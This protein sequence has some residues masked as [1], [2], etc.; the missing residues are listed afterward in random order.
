MKYGYLMAF[1]LFLGNCLCS[2]WIE[3]KECSV[4]L[5]LDQPSKLALETEASLM[6]DTISRLDQSAPD[7]KFTIIHP[8]SDGQ[9]VRR[10]GSPISLSE[11]EKILIFQGDDP[12]E[13][14][15]L[16][17]DK[18]VEQL[19]KFYLEPN[20]GIVLSGGACALFGKLGY[21]PIKFQRIAFG[22]DR[23]QSGIV[24][25]NPNSDLFAN[26]TLDR[27]TVWISNAG[28][29]IYTAMKTES[30][31][32]VQYATA[33]APWS[34]PL[35]CGTVPL[36]ADKPESKKNALFVFPWLIHPVYDRAD[37]EFRANFE[38]LLLNLVRRSGTKI[39]PNDLIPPLWKKPDFQGLRLA[40][41]DIAESFGSEYS[42]SGKYLNRIADLEK[43]SESV[44]T[45]QEADILLKEFAALQKEALLANPMLDFNE[46]LMIRR[47]PNVKSFPEN[48]NGNSVLKPTGYKNELIR[49][50]FRKESESIVYKPE[51]DEFLGDI[52][53]HYDADKL[54]FSMPD[55][56]NNSRWRVWELPLKSQS[57]PVV[58]PLINVNDV[59]NYD[60]CYLPDDRIIFCSTA[61]FTGVPCINGSGHVCNLYLKEK[62]GSIRQ[63]TIDQDHDWCPTVMNN[64]RIMYLRWEYTDLPHAFSRILFHMNPDGTNQS[65]LYG[66]GSYWPNSLFYARPIP[67]HPTKFA[68][69]VTG[70]H[71]MNRIGDL[72][73]F[74]PAK[75]RKEAEGAI[76]RIPGRGKRVLPAMLD[77]PIAQSWPK[78]VHPF[79][80]SEKY[81]L[82]SCKLNASSPWAIC[83]VDVFDNIVPI[84]EEKEFAL[85]EP[86]P[87]RKADRPAVIPD[88]IKPKRSDADVFI[89]DIYQGEGLKGVP[90]GT[91]HALRIFSYQFGYQGMGAEPHS[92]G[93]DGPWDPKRIIGTV[94]VY[95]DGSAAFKIPA[96]TP[97]AFQ[98]LD[99][100]GKAIQIMRS[101]ITAMPGESVSCIGCHEKQNETSPPAPRTIA[102]RSE[103]VAIQPFYGL[104]RGFS[105]DREIQPILD[106]Y[107]IECHQPNSEKAKKILA[108]KKLDLQKIFIP[109]FRTGPR[110]P[111]QD[112]TLSINTKA[113]FS[114]SY[115]QLRRFVRTPTKESQMPIHKPY[116]FHADSTHLIQHLQKGHYGIQL[117]S[118]SWD[119]LF[120]WIDLNAPYHGNWGE[121]RNYEAAAQVAHQYKRRND[122]RAL[123][124]GK[125]PELEDDPNQIRQPIPIAGDPK[126]DP[127]NLLFID[128]KTEIIAPANG[129]G[130]KKAEVESLPLTEGIDLKLVSIPGTD[131]KIGQFE[132][133][134]EQYH[135]FRPGHDSGIEYGDFIQFSPGEMGYLLSRKNQPVV[136]VSWFEAKAFCDWLSQKTGR[137]FTLPTREQWSL[138]ALAGAKTPF[139]FGP[140]NADFTDKENL[141][142]KRFTEISNFSW[143]ARSQ[144][145]PAWRPGDLSRD[146]RARVSAPVG[147]YQP[148]PWGLYD[149]QGN[150]AEWTCSESINERGERKK[151]VVGGSWYTPPQKA[152]ADQIRRFEPQ[153]N[154]FDVG[155]RVLCSGKQ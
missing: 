128:Q 68:A 26:T 81:F 96:Y 144:V 122:L 19:K 45:K 1:I 27:N 50:D 9:F 148:N 4:G 2:A 20:K 146:D 155:F 24:P 58:L 37:R 54:L 104:A 111:L 33:N 57:K 18:I 44:K 78:F 112:N 70:H 113:L 7:L 46:I 67:D 88:R 142:D 29:F 32:V 60:A 25:V 154:L 15:P 31:N 11:F 109:D 36:N 153:V 147:S 99:A 138:A 119:R 126:K 74:D 141:A 125:V 108:A 95:K 41:E 87:I 114:P 75:G 34:I 130:F 6:A 69:I 149:I 63:L 97:L 12:K 116:E 152:G 17:N 98:P 137:T 30:P 150:A 127:R 92:V 79:P 38:H 110:K 84:K 90:R 83:L 118:G 143:K 61:C 89:A 48:Y 22:D 43:R 65:E 107:C 71:D 133:T 115:Y 103:P 86:I 140:I 39:E 124:A 101:W 73:L 151:I 129:S 23:M 106:R 28:Y 76:Q 100:N 47:D 16:F 13:N 145:L 80:L 72:V 51:K 49:F 117:D 14:S 102:A 94:P 55:M 77:L 10:G 59:D 91:V 35:W 105:F 52:E 136:R 56:S 5:L 66:S 3:A 134:N 123:Y 21:G 82:V 120:T 8:S 131:F 53:L 62:N 121:I 64:G 85:Y 139:W 132:I 93:L 42:Q 135:V 40:V